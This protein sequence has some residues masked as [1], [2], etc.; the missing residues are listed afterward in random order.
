MR[1]RR[2]KLRLLGT[3]AASPNAGMHLENEK[4]DPLSDKE[5]EDNSTKSTTVED[6]LQ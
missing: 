3:A 2:H 1:R 4:E 6:S 5:K